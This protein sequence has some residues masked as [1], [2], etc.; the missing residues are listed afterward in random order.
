MFRFPIALALSAAFASAQWTP[1]FSHTTASLR[2]I[3]NLGDGVVWASGSGGTVL[4]TTNGGEV[5]QKCTTPAGA[6]KL[7]FRAIQAFDAQTAVIMSAGT[8]DLSRIYKTNDGCQTWKLVLSNPDKEGFWD[9]MQ[10]AGPGLGVVIGDQV[11]GCF[12]VFMSED[13][14]S[15]WRKPVPDGVRAEQKNQSLFAAS[16]SSL[17]LEGRK[18]IFVTGGGTTSAFELDLQFSSM[19]VHK[20]LAL[21]VGEAAGA[22]SIA[23]HGDVYVAVGGDYKAPDASAGTAVYR[24]G[25]GPWTAAKTPPHGYRSAVGW[26]EGRKLWVAIGPNGADTSSDDGRTWTPIDYGPNWNA[27]SLPFAVGSKGQIGKLK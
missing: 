26:D 22:F 27:I 15:T 4:R 17:L 6:E 20:Q 2:G 13:G 11:D 12:P 19:P 3:Q 9:A 14:G 24:V 18:L 21:A 10:F 23:S 5:W 25:K 1:Q 7:D 16:N 8:G